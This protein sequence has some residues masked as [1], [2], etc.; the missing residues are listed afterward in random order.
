MQK[1]KKIFSILAILI[2]AAIAYYYSGFSVVESGT[3]LKRD[4][5]KIEKSDVQNIFENIN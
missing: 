3:V 1:N 2:I 4:T 5:I